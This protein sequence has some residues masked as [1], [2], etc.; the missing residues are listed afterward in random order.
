MKVVK[1]EIENIA[2]EDAPYP[3]NRVV[4]TTED[5]RRFEVQGVNLH[6]LDGQVMEGKEKPE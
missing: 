1:I 6:K 2:G 3:Y 4:M 5:G